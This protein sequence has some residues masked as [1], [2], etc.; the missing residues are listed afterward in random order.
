MFPACTLSYLGQGA[1]ILQDQSNI[2]AP[3]FLLTPDWALIPMV[4]LATAATVIASQ[5]VIT[6]AFSV[7]AQAAQLGYLPRLRI[8]HTSRSAHGQIYVPWINWLLMISVLTLVFAFRDSASLAY[9]FGMAV[10]GTITIATILFFYVAWRTWQTPKWFLA[11]L[12]V[13]LLAVDL[14]FLAA[15]LTKLVHGAW[16]PLAI[17]VT[18]F[19]VMTTWQRGRAVVTAKREAMEGSL[20]AF[21]DG[22]QDRPVPVQVV[23]GTAIFL[24]RGNETAPLALRSNVEHNHVRHEH[25]AVVA[26]EIAIVPRVPDDERV[27]VEHLGE[28]EDGITHLTVR[29]GY[30]ER[31]DVPAALARL[32]PEDTEGDLDL[33][34]ATYF[35]S[36]IELRLG[37][38]PGCRPGGA[39]CSSRRRSSPPTRPNTS[40]CRGTGRCCWARTSTC[41]PGDLVD[42]YTPQGYIWIVPAPSG[43]TAQ[44]RSDSMNE[45]HDHS[46]S[47]GHAGHSG[48][49]DHGDHVG[50][51]RR[52]FWIML[53]LAVPVVGFSGMFAMILGYPLPDAAWVDRG[54]TAARHRHVRVGRVAV[55]DRR[56]QRAPHAQAGHDAAD[57]ARD[58]RRVRRLPRRE[59]RPARP[60]ARLLVGARAPDRHHAARPLDRDAL[61]R[62]D[63]VRPGLSRGAAARR[64][65][66][67]RRRPDRQGLAGRP[68]GGR[69]RRGP[70]RRERPR[71]RPRR[72]RARGDGRVDGDG[73]VAHR[74][75]RPGRARDRGHRRHGLRPADRGHRHRRRHRARRH[76]AARHRGAELVVARA[77]P[78]RR[79]SGLAVLV[80]AGRRGD[81]R[82][83]LVA[84][85]DARRR[86]RPHRHR[87]GH[88]VPP[89]PRPRHPA[90]RLHRDRARSPRRRARQG[91][92]RA[93]EHAHRGHRAVR[94]DRHPHQGRADRRR[95]RACRRPRRRRDQYRHPAG[96]RR[97]R[98]VG[99]RAPAGQGRSA[100]GPRARPHG[101]ARLRLHL[102]ARRGRDRD[103]RRPRGARRR[104]APARGERPGRAAR[105]GRVAPRRRDHPA[106]LARRRR[107]RRD[108][109]R[110]RG[111]RRVRGR[112]PTAARPRA[113][114]WS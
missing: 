67:R 1:L 105:G 71:R 6:G 2:S 80:R 114:R 89:R 70:A 101:P 60:P 44:P 111:A 86:S 88:R 110:G 93:G 96:A 41:R 74:P 33:E 29:F 54:L 37:D 73:G 45:L 36:R 19:T 28:G 34:N 25:V 76:P 84:R 24:N 91:P 48:H 21:V 42:G 12:A 103:G 69:R 106:R 50:Q 99:Q 52:L 72:R 15:N 56:R 68:R 38:E 27:T 18:A 17:G 5:A 40:L 39:V 10:T 23:S 49:G 85:R 82:G 7:T 22:L 59:P 90:R 31:P 75:A 11:T 57:R 78:G 32:G 62:A 92:P 3:F 47:A 30:G 43:V 16:L 63:D 108:Q 83:R 51:F 65:G 112:R 97:G 77:T 66:A 104:P 107:D 81:H 26:V 113:S 61:A 14:L 13:V 53:V 64:G 9:A 102:V 35:L 95:R 98:R 58:H 55:P 94:Q 87:P 100:R 4:V 20:R 8:L 109:A 79:R 46:T